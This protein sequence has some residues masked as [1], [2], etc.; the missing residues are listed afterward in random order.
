MPMAKAVFDFIVVG[1]GSAGC[2]VASR[3][4]ERGKSVLLVEAGGDNQQ[5][6]VKS[7][8]FGSIHLQGSDLDWKYETVPQ[9]VTGRT[10]FWPRGRVL[11]GC[12]SINQ[13]IWVRGDPRTFDDWHKRFGCHGWSWSDVV[14]YFKRC[15]AFQGPDPDEVRGKDG[16]IVVSRAED[17]NL[18]TKR[19]CEMFLASCSQCGIPEGV[20]Y[21]GLGQDGASMVQAN[22]DKGVR[23]DS[24]SAY[25]LKLRALDLENLSLTTGDMATKVLIEGQTAKGVELQGSD[26]KYEVRA[27]Q[28][29]VLCCGAIG[30]PQ[31]LMCSGIGP[32]E[33]LDELGI[34]CVKDLPVGNN[35]QDHILWPLVFQTKDLE[36]NP[37]RP[38]TGG[39]VGS[40]GL[41]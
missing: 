40:L 21:N 29:V 23:S 9:K 1:A 18:A 31:L 41:S 14:P 4:A 32:R 10:S 8:F 6:R 36:F 3:L 17:C 39:F 35:L 38:Y 16:P 12:S 15:E 2:V 37:A 27:R 28:E 11:G 26:G 30:C 22:V 13:M 33:H 24:A 25:L 7:P 19:V 34:A 5:S 20:D